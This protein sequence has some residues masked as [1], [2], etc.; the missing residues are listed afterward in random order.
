ML[1][2]IMTWLPCSSNDLLMSSAKHTELNHLS[3]SQQRSVFS[4]IREAI[5]S[6]SC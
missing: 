5:G 2:K 6:L 1:G 4:G 3:V